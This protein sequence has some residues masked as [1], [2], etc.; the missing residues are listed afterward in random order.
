MSEPAQ[1]AVF[2][3]KPGLLRGGDRLEG[4][5][6]IDVAAPQNLVELSITLHGA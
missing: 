2:V 1:L 3:Q 5:L 6:V 4:V